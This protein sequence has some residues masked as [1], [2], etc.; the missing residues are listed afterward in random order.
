MLFSFVISHFIVAIKR[1]GE[2]T[3]KINV[4]AG[5]PLLAMMEGSIDSPEIFKFLSQVLVKLIHTV[6][7][8]LLK[9][10]D[11]GLLKILVNTA[12]GLCVWRINN[13]W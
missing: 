1:G 7:N 5:I 13:R 2:I 8:F 9:A 6:E 3:R 12:R 10:A 4:L 11:Q